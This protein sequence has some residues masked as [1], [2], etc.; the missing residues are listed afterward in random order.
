MVFAYES[1]KQIE[2]LKKLDRSTIQRQDIAV[3]LV[4]FK[5]VQETIE[6]KATEK[7]TKQTADAKEAQQKRIKRK[8]QILD[9]KYQSTL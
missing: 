6:K 8:T 9:R 5:E 3:C 4:K 7:V 1:I 2:W